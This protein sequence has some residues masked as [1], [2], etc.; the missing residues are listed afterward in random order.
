MPERSPC[1]FALGAP[2]STLGLATGEAGPPPPS[3]IRFPRA[4]Q[5]EIRSWRS[6]ARLVPSRIGQRTSWNRR[7]DTEPRSTK[8]A[9]ASHSR[10]YLYVLAFLGAVHDHSFPVALVGGG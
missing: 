8:T 9:V 5:G 1:S 3:G 10:L 2:P 7:L 4:R 6:T